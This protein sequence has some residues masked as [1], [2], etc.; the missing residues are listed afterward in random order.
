M[1]VRQ[2]TGGEW[3]D[4]EGNVLALGTV[5][6]EVSGDAQLSSSAG[7]LCAGIK[8]ILQLDSTGSVSVASNQSLWPTDQMNPSNITY[9]VWVYAA[10]GELSWGPNY[11]LT[12]PSGAGTFD[13]DTWVPNQIGSSSGASAG[14]LTLQTNGVNNGSQ[15][16]LNLVNGANITIT[17]D[18]TGDVTIAS[19]GSSGP[20]ARGW[21]GWTTDGEAGIHPSQGFGCIPAAN[22]AGGASNTAINP[23]ATETSMTGF[24]TSA[25]PS[26][27]SFLDWSGGNDYNSLSLGNLGLAETRMRLGGTTTIRCWIGLGVNFGN[28]Y[29]S[30]TPPETTVAFRYSTAAGDTHWQ[31]V[32]SDG[33]TQVTVATTVA[34]DAN[35]HTFGIEPSGTNF[36]FFIDGIQVASVSR[37][38]TT[39][40]GTTLMNGF[41]SV[42]N[43][44]TAN[45]VFA[46]VAYYYWDTNP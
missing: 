38:T 46:A 40:V 41:F 29:K 15:Q 7:E 3:Q 35:G 6:C 28:F 1:A 20:R 44:G 45:N 12:V 33:T 24:T 32:V 5:V 42:D 34:P 39:L 2:V 16:L 27:I 8:V 25:N 13:L 26:S 31:C 22:L 23:T 37:T 14:S 9:T 11:G 18:G 17:Q 43:A 19:S 36:L 10:N 30:D 21:R 4:A